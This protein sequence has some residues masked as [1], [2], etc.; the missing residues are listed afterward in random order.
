V[1]HTFHAFHLPGGATYDG[2]LETLTAGR[3]TCR[4]PA[5]SVDLLS[6]TIGALHRA[7]GRLAERPVMEI[8][9]VVDAAASRLADPADPLRQ[10]AERLVPAATG[11]SP[12]MA[13]LVLDCMSADWR[14]EPL[15]R[16][17]GAE[18]GEPAVLD[19][20]VPTGGHRQTR[21]YGPRL[22]FHIFAGNVPGVAVTSLVRSLLVKAPVLAKL[23]SGE[24]VLPVLFARAVASIDATVGDALAVTYWRGGDPGPEALALREA[25]LVVVYGGEEVVG[26]MRRRARPGQRLV[27]HGP[28]FSAGIVTAPALDRDLPALADQV[29][30]AVA[31]FDQQG[32]V[33][34][35][36]VWV[37]D[38]GGDRTD[39]FAS[40]VADAL[41]GVEVQLPRGDITPAEASQIHQERGAAEL[42]GHAGRAVRVLAGKGTTWTVV[43]DR[44]PAFRPSCLNRF[45]HVLPVST[46]QAAVDAL[47][48]HGSYLQSVA[49]A[50]PPDV[51]AELAY[52]LAVAGATRITTF[53]RLP[54]PPPEWH[55]DGRGPLREL[56]RWVDLEH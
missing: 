21:A 4:Y 6:G 5:P 33:S 48:P 3:V 8:V 36:V 40:A 14:A 20:F 24:P 23:A 39:A 54:W 19:R 52:R 38:P 46:L 9:E 16:M 1:S 10:E 29:A 56:L 45:L 22:S 35:H 7:R 30:R 42:R 47:A 2:P 25:D 13:R 27:V 28:R 43:V 41:R 37:E 53:E 51:R 50:G 55:H 12:A 49:V 17:L 44:D 32:C 15:R 31:Y 26:S 18:L 34:P 11:Y